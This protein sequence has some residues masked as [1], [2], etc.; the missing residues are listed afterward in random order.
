MFHISACLFKEL[1][2]KTQSVLIGQLSHA[3]VG[4]THYF[5]VTDILN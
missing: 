1:L 3:W 2:K 4:T 5:Y